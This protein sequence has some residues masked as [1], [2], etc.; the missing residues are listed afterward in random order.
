MCIRDSTIITDWFGQAVGIY[1]RG[2]ANATGVYYDGWNNLF[3]FD[4]NLSNN[5]ATQYTVTPFWDWIA[6]PE[7]NATGSWVNGITIEGVR[8]FWETN[9]SLYRFL[10]TAR[11]Q[12]DYFDGNGT[13]DDAYGSLLVN[14]Q[15]KGKN[16]D[17]PGDANRTTYNS[18]VLGSEL[19]ATLQPT[20]VPAL[21]ASAVEKNAT[22]EVML[23]GVVDTISPYWRGSGYVG[24]K[25]ILAGDG[26][27]AIL[28]PVIKDGRLE[29]VVIE[30]AGRGYS[31]SLIHI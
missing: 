21:P 11:E 20:W 29:K 3:A 8:Y 22:F 30:D 17:P 25:V 6:I 28:H 10:D 13:I 7:S 19:N 31:L 26:S 14:I 16:Y 27:G 2:D 1:K 15:E 24:P 18:Y 12:K 23:G 4:G 9:G 5:I